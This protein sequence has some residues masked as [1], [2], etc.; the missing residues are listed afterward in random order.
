[1]SYLLRVMLPDRPGS[2]GSLAVALGTVD[3]DIVSLDVVDRFDGVAVDDI[4]VDVPHGTFPDTLITAAERLDGV[5]VDSLRPFGGILDA[6]RELELIDAVAGAGSGAAQMLADELPAALRV[7]WALVLEVT[8]DATCRLVARGES[9]PMWDGGE[10]PVV[11]GLARVTALSDDDEVPAEWTAMDTALAAAPLNAGHVLVVG[12][13]GGPSFRP[14][15]I[16]RLG[17]L[18]GILRS[19]HAG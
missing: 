6:H 18:T 11:C 14:S 10:V 12:R 8:G 17:Y 15:E 7:G 4:V 2:L 5:V 3:A 1:M 13:P 9:A 16:A 19:L